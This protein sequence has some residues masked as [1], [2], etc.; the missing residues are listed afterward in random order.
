MAIRDLVTKFGKK[1][2]PIQRTPGDLFGSLHQEI[3]R[4]FDNFG[5]GFFDLSPLSTTLLEPSGT[6]GFSPKVDIKEN[7]KEIEVTAELPGMDEK[8]VQVSLAHNE[9]VIRGEKKTEKEEK[10]KEWYRMERSYGSFH[11]LV[12]LPEGVDTSKADATFKKGLL[13]VTV[14]K[15]ANAKQNQ[16][17]KITIQR[18]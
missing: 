5:R 4:V 2:V 16:A 7:D 10:G 13:T 12:N 3:N 17:K 1:S 6:G 9:L 8:D 14:P 15:R 11:R 18:A